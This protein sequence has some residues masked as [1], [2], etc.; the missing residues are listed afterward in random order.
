VTPSDDRLFQERAEDEAIEE[1]GDPIEVRKMQFIN[2]W[3]RIEHHRPIARQE[4]DD[5]IKL[6]RKQGVA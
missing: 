5:L 4:L 6:V 2:R 1:V 3:V